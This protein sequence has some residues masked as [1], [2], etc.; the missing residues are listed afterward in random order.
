MLLEGV[1]VPITTPFY[2][3]GRVYLRKLE[4]NVR[5]LS[6]TPVSGLIA[7]GPNSEYTSLSTDEKRTILAATAD[8]AAPEKVLIA[9]ISEAGVQPALELADYAAAHLF[10]AVLLAAPAAIDIPFWHSGPQAGEPTT[11]LLTWFRS[12][13]DRSPLPILLASHAAGGELPVLTV[14]ALAHHPNILGLLEQSTHISRVAALRQATAGI[15]RTSTTTVTFTAATTR[16]LQPP[17]PA[18]TGNLLSAESLATGGTAVAIPPS[19]PA[20]KTRTKQTG[21]Q[22]LWSHAAESIAAFRAGASAV[23]PAAA[24]SVP[25]AVFEIW[26]AWKDG[27][28]ALMHEKEQRVTTAEAYL[29]QQGV[30]AI[31]AAAE[32]SGYF[33]GRPRLPQL[34][35]T[36]QIQDHIAAILD[37][38]RS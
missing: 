19:T 31:K 16:M 15:Q 8:T 28:T 7:L 4:H 32:L 3:D 36:A 14:A 29:L 23:A 5:R 27:D 9:G 26:A 20:L 34:P 12:I 13:A 11:E 10:D 17:P 25:G 21:F 30:P 38:M 37:G 2:P 35:P 24:A 22:L 33:G 18:P 1:H 6:L